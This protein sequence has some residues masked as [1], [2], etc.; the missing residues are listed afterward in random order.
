ML[1][2]NIINDLLKKYGPIRLFQ[3]GISGIASI[4]SIYIFANYFDIITYGYYQLYLSTFFIFIIFSFPG[5]KEGINQ[6]VSNNYHSSLKIATTYGLKKSIL[7]SIIILLTSF[8]YLSKENYTLFIA[9]VFLSLIFPFLTQ[10]KN[11]LFYYEG[12]SK[13]NLVSSIQ[14]FVSLNM[15]F[16]IIINAFLRLENILFIIIPIQLF[17]IITYYYH[18]NK[19]NSRSFEQVKDPDLISYSN[20]NT[21]ITILITISNHIDQVIIGNIFG[22]Q[23]LAIF[24][25]AISLPMGA[26]NF[27]NP[28]FSL[29][30]PKFANQEII[31]TKKFIP[32]SY[33]IFIVLNLMIYFISIY[34][35]TL[36]FPTYENT[37]VYL[38]FIC[39]ILVVGMQNI[40][41]N[42]YHRARKN[43]QI[44]KKG[45]INSSFFYLFLLTILGSL[46]GI[47]GILFS[48]LLKEILLNF[49]YNRSL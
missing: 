11:V 16:V 1:Q 21:R 3:S 46:F 36:L 32:Y 42:L 25:I 38:L 24:V 29:F 12:R 7:G 40:L 30:Y 15:L 39:V 20:F 4:V 34:L 8:Y 17:E 9:F 45:V 22:P 41:L 18:Y 49:Y 44:L 37:F 48:Q 2:I 23:E 13:F 5:L 47:I 26:K 31:I 14:I 27:L 10:F 43:R 19:I 6:S 35:Y 33:M 28:I